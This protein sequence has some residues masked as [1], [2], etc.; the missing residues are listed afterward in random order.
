MSWQSDIGGMTLFL[1]SFLS[2]ILLARNVYKLPGGHV[3][4]YIVTAGF[5]DLEPKIKEKNYMI[6]GT[7]FACTIIIDNI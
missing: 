3:L 4:D 7:W 2:D 6:F 1:S 5:Q